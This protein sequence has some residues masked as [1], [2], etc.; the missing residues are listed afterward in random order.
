[1]PARMVNP[2]LI[3]PSAGSKRGLHYVSATDHRIPNMGEVDMNFMT[4]E[5]GIESTIVFQVAD[6]NK[7]LMSLSDR[8]DNSCRLVFDQD[9]ETGEDLTHMY[10]KKSKKKMKLKRVGKVWVLDCTVP[11]TFL[12]KSSSVFSRPG[13]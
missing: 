7:P 2:S 4:V 12:A 3:R 1:M 10:D 6:V 13:A 9:D 11:A 8:V 5:E